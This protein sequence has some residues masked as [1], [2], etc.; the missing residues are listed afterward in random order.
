MLSFE[1]KFTFKMASV[2]NFA[3]RLMNGMTVSFASS[4]LSSV[5]VGLLSILSR[6]S[7]IIGGARVNA[8]CFRP[9]F[10]VC[11]LSVILEGKKKGIPNYI[12]V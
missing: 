6:L 2:L 9:L 3:G 11:P 10:F 12:V 5:D 4:S 7:R 8:A 1:R